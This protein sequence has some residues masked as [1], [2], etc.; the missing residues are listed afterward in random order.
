MCEAP[1]RLPALDWCLHFFYCTFI[2]ILGTGF[3]VTLTQKNVSI[4]HMEDTL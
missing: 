3:I 2:N 4:N 1:K